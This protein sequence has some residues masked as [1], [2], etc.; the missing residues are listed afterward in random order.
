MIYIQYIDN[1]KKF[2]LIFE[3]RFSQVAEVTK[4]F[5]AVYDTPE[6]SK[7]SS[8]ER[9]YLTPFLYKIYDVI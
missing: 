2:R 3:S 7:F 1:M 4:A 8:K 6:K 9:V 5:L